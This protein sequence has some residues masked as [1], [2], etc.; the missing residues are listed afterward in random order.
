VLAAIV[1]IMVAPMR[2]L[3][4][5][6][7]YYVAATRI[8]AREGVSGFI[9]RW[10]IDDH[11]P[12]LAPLIHPLHPI[13]AGPPELRGRRAPI[14]LPAS[15]ALPIVA[16]VVVSLVMRPRRKQWG[17]ALSMLAGSIVVLPVALPSLRSQ[18][19]HAIGLGPLV[20]AP[21]VGA[22]AALGAVVVG[23]LLLW[24]PPV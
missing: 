15:G 20:G 9:P 22:L 2:R 6:E 16:S 13:G 1:R 4:P 5:D 11:P 19:A 10:P 12:L 23:Q 17:A 18:I 7:A 3:S 8:A 21:Y 24:S 14:R